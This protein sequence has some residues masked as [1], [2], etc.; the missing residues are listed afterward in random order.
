M[1]VFQV[2]SWFIK[3]SMLMPNLGT[4]TDV[5]NK[6]IF[7]ERDLGI[8][9]SKFN[10]DK[11]SLVYWYKYNQMIMGDRLRARTFKRPY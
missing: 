6:L 3:A 1:H 7:Y 8:V 4:Q 11:L 9:M 2:D 5:S 10:L